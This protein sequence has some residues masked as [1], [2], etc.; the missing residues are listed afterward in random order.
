MWT[1]ALSLYEDIIK[2]YP[3]E[4]VALNSAGVECMFLN[5]DDKALEY[6]NRAVKVAPDNYKGFYNR[7]LLHLKN[8]KP[9]LAI[10]SFN[11][12]LKLY[13]YH[14]AYAGR[15][16]AYYMI[17]DFPKAILDANYVLRNDKQ[18]TSSSASRAHF[19][20]GNC[21][22]DMNKLEEAMKEYNKCLEINNEEPD[23]YFKRAIVFGKKQD[24]NSCLGDLDICLKFNPKYY[25]AYYWKGVAKVNLKLNPCEEFKLAAVQN[26][27]PA[28]NAY[29]KYCR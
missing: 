21:Y 17:S 19:V 4:F 8:K 22:S 18:I 6:L 11:Q 27:Q 15:A 2:K 20:L 16:S 24:F 29:N 23:F 3:D 26:I 5:Q 28:I 25:E 7:G 14:K 10:N 1:S 13:D 9:E 12:T